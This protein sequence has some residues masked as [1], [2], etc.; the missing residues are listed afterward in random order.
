MNARIGVKP[1]RISGPRAFGCSSKR[2]NEYAAEYTKEAYAWLRE[3]EAEASAVEERRFRRVLAWA[4]VA[5]VG[6]VIGA[7]A[8]CIAAWPVIAGWLGLAK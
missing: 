8:G 4:I 3:R 5:G 1:S 2:A 7:M 6:A